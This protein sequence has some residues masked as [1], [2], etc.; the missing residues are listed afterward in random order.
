MLKDIIH[1]DFLRTCS[2][3]FA[4]VWMAYFDH[5]VCK[6]SSVF[7]VSATSPTF[8]TGYQCDG[9]TYSSSRHGSCE[10]DNRRV[11]VIRWGQHV[12]GLLVA[13]GCC[14][15]SCHFTTKIRSSCINRGSAP[16]KLLGY[17]GVAVY[18][19]HHPQTCR[20]WGMVVPPRRHI[21]VS[22]EAQQHARQ[23]LPTVVSLLDVILIDFM[24]LNIFISPAI[25]S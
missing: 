15:S 5:H 3:V 22:W 25:E 10:H 19:Y 21:I 14:L 11:P 23:M 2:C 16:V 8:L 7:S 18:I 4:W 13:Q 9:S 12:L 20:E 1:Y 24:F 6:I 17:W